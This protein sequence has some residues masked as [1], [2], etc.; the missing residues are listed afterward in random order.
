MFGIF[1]LFCIAKKSR[2]KTLGIGINLASVNYGIL[3]RSY[4]RWSLRGCF[5]VSVTLKSDGCRGS[6]RVPALPLVFK[7]SAFSSQPLALFNAP[8]KPIYPYADP[9]LRL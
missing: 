5:A 4:L 9:S 1:L 8:E 6:L 7:S 3:L 2:Q